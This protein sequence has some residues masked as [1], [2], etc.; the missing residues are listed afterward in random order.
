MESRVCEERERGNEEGEE[1]YGKKEVER[2]WK[3]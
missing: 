1:K 2:E 3:R